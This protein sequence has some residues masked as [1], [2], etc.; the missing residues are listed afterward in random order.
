MYTLD[1]GY[2]IMAQLERYSIMLWVWGCYP[3]LER[4]LKKSWSGIGNKTCAITVV[5]DPGVD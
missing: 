2:H 5:I 3:M 4:S 1:I